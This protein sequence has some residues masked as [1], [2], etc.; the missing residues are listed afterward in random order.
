[1]RRLRLMVKRAA[2]T[3]PLVVA[4]QVAPA[5][6]D[7]HANSPRPRGGGGAGRGGDAGQ[8]ADGGSAGGGGNTGG[9]GSFG[10][11]GSGGDWGFGGIDNSGTG[12]TPPDYVDPCV[13]VV[14]LPEEGTPAEAGQICAATVLPVESNRATRVTLRQ[15][16]A[17]PWGSVSLGYI[18]V[19]PQLAPLLVGA[20]N[21]EL[22]EVTEAGL[23][24]AVVTPLDA[25]TPDSPAFSVQWAAPLSEFAY[26]SMVRATFR[27]TA[28]I[29]CDEGT[30]LTHSATDVHLCGD[31]DPAWASSGDECSVCRIIA[32]MAPS[33]IVPDAAADNLPLSQAVRLRLVE[34]ARVSNTVVLLAENDGGPDMDYQ[35]H[36]S[37]GELRQLAPDVVAWTLSDGLAAP[38]IQA[39]VIGDDGAAVGT[40]SFN[41]RAG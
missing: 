3:L 8:S 39:A 9:G 27:V 30:Q 28:E 40:F 25:L 26:G 7:S 19:D 10:G 18:E 11:G 4:A 17:D 1:M 12:G 34:L 13:Y 37:G 29:Q 41:D 33:P 21:V 16:P 35:W 14:E 5:C 6:T 23:M 24:P 36:A 31:W 32:E 22:L 15:D 2:G 38:Y 20:R